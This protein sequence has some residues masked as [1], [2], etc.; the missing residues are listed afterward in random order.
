MPAFRLTYYRVLKLGAVMLAPL[1][2]A[3]CFFTSETPLD[4]AWT[5]HS[6]GEFLPAGFHIL[7][8]EDGDRLFVRSGADFLEVLRQG[9]GDEPTR[10]SS[11]KRGEAFPRDVFVA[12]ARE[13][14]KTL[15][16]E[17]ARKTEAEKSFYVAFRAEKDGVEWISWSSIPQE[18]ASSE[19][20]VKKIEQALQKED[21]KR[22]RLLS[23]KET[24]AALQDLAARQLDE[25]EPEKSAKQKDAVQPPRQAAPAPIAPKPAAPPSG[26]DALDVGDIVYVQGFFS[27]ELAQIVRLDKPSGRVK[28]RLQADG[29]TKWVP[30]TE[31]L[32]RDQSTEKMIERGVVGGAILYC[33]LNPEACQ[34]K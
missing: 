12:I 6:F 30:H 16:S 4:T 15:S 10:F 5:T 7:A 24:A 23:P 18:V 14:D 1:A 28:V 13:D 22:F 21:T 34:N 29:T 20:M 31:V 3:G 33:I 19:D 2:L 17:K 8:A 25:E 11:V 9:L 32:T 27:D 26:I